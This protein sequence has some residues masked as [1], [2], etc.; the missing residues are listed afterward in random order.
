MDGVGTSRSWRTT[1]SGSFVTGPPALT[2]RPGRIR[3]LSPSS[4]SRACGSSR[5]HLRVRR[6]Q[7]AAS[8]PAATAAGHHRDGPAELHCQRHGQR[9]RAA[10]RLADEPA[11]QRHGPARLGE[12]RH[13]EASRPPGPRAASCRRSDVGDPLRQPHVGRHR[14]VLVRLRTVSNGAVERSPGPT[15][16]PAGDR[17]RRTSTTTPSTSAA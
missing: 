8:S 12:A 16:I 17:P 9:R 14:A 3:R 1:T 6:R 4:T 15:R 10:H 5:C 7:P 11:R 13:R 2:K